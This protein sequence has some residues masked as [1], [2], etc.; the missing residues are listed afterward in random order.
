M[1]LKAK[2]HCCE[3]ASTASRD[4]YIPCNRPATQVV[5]HRDDADYRMCDMCANHNIKNRGAVFAGVYVRESGGLEE[6]RATFE[7]ALRN[8]LVHMT[9]TEAMSIVAAYAD[10]D[11]VEDDD[12]PEPAPM[13]EADLWGA[14]DSGRI[15]FGLLAAIAANIVIWGLVAKWVIS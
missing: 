3:E 5:R 11:E 7:M 12:A 15:N 13:T 1:D 6:A 14:P 4:F 9:L 8:L 10:P 2:D